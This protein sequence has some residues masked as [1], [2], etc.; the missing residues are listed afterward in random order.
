MNPRSVISL[1]GWRPAVTRLPLD[2]RRSIG[3]VVGTATLIGGLALTT[4]PGSGSARAAASPAISGV[5]ADRPV[6]K[7][8]QFTDGEV[9]AIT[10]VGN[11]IVAGGTFTGV[12]PAIRGAAGVVDLTAG[13]FTAGFPEVVGSVLTAVADG[14]GGY[15]IGGNF[16]SVGGQARTHVAHILANFTVDPAFAPVLDAPVRSIVVSGVNVV[17]AGAFTSVNST[18]TIGLAALDVNGVKAWG[19]G[20]NSS[21]FVVA[22]NADGSRLY[23]GGDFTAFAGNTN[24][25]RLAAVDPLTG[26]LDPTF[27][28]GIV[29]LAVRDLA[30]VG[31][32]L[33]LAGEFTRVNNINRT[34]LAVVDAA[35]GA[36]NPLVPAGPNGTVRSLAVSPDGATL[37]LGGDFTRLG[38]TNVNGFAAVNTTTGASAIAPLTM[39]GT[40][41]DITL[42]GAGSAYLG[43]NFVL[44]PEKTVPRTLAKI[45]LSTLAVTS[46][47]PAPALPLSLARP[48]LD[49]SSVRTIALVGT[50]LLVGGDFSDYGTVARSYLAAWDKTTGAL[51][52]NFNPQVNNTVRALDGAV[53]GMSVYVGGDFTTVNGSTVNRIAKLSIADGS[54][55]SAFTTST[56]AY[57]KEIVVHPD[58]SRVFV[59][60]N[61][62][63]TNGLPTERFVGVDATSG[64]V[65]P[66]YQ[67]DLTNPTN[68]ASEGGVRAMA[69]SPDNTRLAII[70]NFL[71]VEGAPRPLATVLDVSDSSTAAVTNWSTP[72]YTQPCAGGRV[73]W[74]RD[75]TYSPDGTR[76][77]IVSSGHLF[78][79]ACDSANAFDATPTADTLP[80]WTARLGDT[81]ESVAATTDAVYVGGHF[82]FLDW[83]HQT[84]S[85]FQLGA[86]HPANGHALSWNAPANGFRGILVLEAEPSGLFVGGDNTAVSGVPHGR[87]AQFTWPSG[88]WLRRTIDHHM[89]LAAGDTVT[90]TLSVTNPGTTPLTLN[91][92]TDSL[93]GDVTGQGTCVPTAIAAASTFA[94]SYTQTVPA[95]ANGTLT[96]AS[97]TIAADDGQPITITDHTTL[98]SLTAYKGAD[99]RSVVGPITAP[100]PSSSVRWSVT[101]WNDNEL[102]PM[103]VTSL[104]STLH[105]DLNGQGTCVAPRTI[106]PYGMYQCMYDGVVSGQIGDTISNQFRMNYVLNGVADIQRHTT[107][108]TVSRPLNG[109]EVL[110]VV[111]N[112]TTVSSADVKLH[113][114]LGQLGF[115]PVYID[116]DVATAADATG[117]LLVY[118]SATSDPLKVGTKFAQVP[119]SV[120]TGTQT[121]YDEMGLTSVADQGVVT[122]TS[123]AVASPLHPLISPQVGT[124]PV[125][126]SARPITWGVPGAAATVISTVAAPGGPKPSEFVYLPGALLADGSTASACRIGFPAEKTSLAKW[127]S[128][129]T[130]MFDRA[131]RWSV[132][133]CG[134]GIIS[135]V[136]GNGSATS[137]GTGGVA[138]AAGLNDPFG[139]A[140]DAQGGFFVA[141]FGANKVRYVTPS[142]TINA[143]A[144]TST[145]GSSGDGGPASAALLKTPSRVRIDPNGL[146]VIVDTGNHKI[147]RVDAN[148]IITTIA[149]TGSGGFTGDGGP[150]TAA[151]LA[152][153]YDVT[154]DAAGNMFIADRSNHRI[155]KVA[156]NG[157][158]T[159]V[160]GTGVSGY[161]GDGITATTA[162]LFNPYSVAVS[163][164]GLLIA[165][166][167]NSR[168][169]L[170]D[171]NGI[172]Q[173]VA[174]TGLTTGGGDGGPATLAD[175][176]K[177]VCLIMRASGGYFICDM[178]NNRV[179]YVNAD[180]II[181]TSV[182]VGTAGFSGDGDLAAY[183]M[184][185]RFTSAAALPNG[186]LVVVDRFNRRVRVVVNAA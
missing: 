73:G 107:S 70:G 1:R 94:C 96:I 158:I 74:M 144:G 43:G 180:G 31:S 15:W 114:R 123:V 50:S 133:G 82:R 67:V 22:P 148:G 173:T 60:G 115:L 83:E 81:I 108:V 24:V 111:G 55:I 161:N 136:A 101:M 89:V 167:D 61:F 104:V 98:R 16:T 32:N 184:G 84:D 17:V 170:V 21:L 182:G 33:W 100:F 119:S 40:V 140:A 154:W 68:D 113:T 53:D 2:T 58:G 137:S 179:R 88:P 151:K 106:A 75:V 177:P 171:A 165:D 4:S 124:V 143:F 57:V 172:I 54:R 71:T 166:Y 152:S 12:G 79:P 181:S 146:V 46:V 76:L 3:I 129:M 18:P 86:L 59:G 138:T 36:L 90:V 11:R 103:D 62:R 176:H 52:L 169:R 27:V 13:N 163:P 150:A 164:E 97:T 157:I 125:V 149:G 117:K 159:T 41:F 121:L 153:P 174:G 72:I 19:G 38:T 48:A 156:I 69:L 80:I 77:Y 185:N 183:A 110:L 135:T 131:V 175:L 102:V 39:T 139:V 134:N 45:N 91:T 99:I 44:T 9:R 92:F 116:D 162:R 126:S 63:F 64:A 28:P 178:N 7:A 160:A 118:L 23:V 128:Q 130:A 30:V 186:D 112:A 95:L 142:G 85:R 132:Y 87:V 93:S 6:D 78:Y 66:G 127:T 141:E 14:G 147:R 56:D 65:L 37:Y 10:E 109:G 25:R 8:L 35:T 26:V 5:V 29:N 47:V 20:P 34:R 155:R 122:T 51:D 42:D 49:G 168:V 145:A 120:M 105:G